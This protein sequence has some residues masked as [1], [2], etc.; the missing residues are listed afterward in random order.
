[1][2]SDSSLDEEL[3]LEQ[4]EEGARL[5][6]ASGPHVGAAARPRSRWLQRVVAFSF[7][8]WSVARVAARMR[9]RCL[10]AV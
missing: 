10:P 8:W 3:L 5:L 6:R 9:S 1:M 2:E 4:T 7:G